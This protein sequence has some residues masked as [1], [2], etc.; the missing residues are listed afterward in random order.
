MDLEK[1]WIANAY[2][3]MSRR[4]FLAQVSAAGAAIAGFAIASK[5]VAGEIIF[6]DLLGVLWDD[7]KEDEKPKVKS[8]EQE[9][10]LEQQQ[11]QV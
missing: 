5:A 6:L 10:P 11:E 8:Q 7:F 4:Q 2:E 1:D 9:K 3:G